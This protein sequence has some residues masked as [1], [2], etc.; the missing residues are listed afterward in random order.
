MTR[1]GPVGV[2][3]LRY[4]VFFVAVQY[5]LLLLASGHDAVK[6]PQWDRRFREAG[7]LEL[8]R[9]GV[10][11][12][13]NTLDELSA[14]QNMV[15]NDPP[16][17]YREDNGDTYEVIA[18]LRGSTDRARMAAELD[19]R[20]SWLLG[21]ALERQFRRVRNVHDI[22]WVHRLWFAQ[23]LLSS[24][25]VSVRGAIWMVPRSIEV[26]GNSFGT[27]G[28]HVS[29]SAVLAGAIWWGLS[30]GDSEMS[31][32]V[33]SL[34]GAGLIG[35]V[36]YAVG[37]VWWAVV[38]AR[39]GLPE[40]WERRGIVRGLCVLVALGAAF[41]L[42]VSGTFQRTNNALMGLVDHLEPVDGSRP[43]YWHGIILLGVVGWVVRNCVRSAANPLLVTKDRLGFVMTA[44]MLTGVGVACVG[45]VL[46]VDTSGFVIAAGC[47]V[48]GSFCG[49]GAMIAFLTVR[50]RL[51]RY[52]ALAAA[53]YTVPRK[54]FRCWALVTWI[55]V[56]GALLAWSELTTS[57]PGSATYVIEQ[58]AALVVMLTLMSSFVPGVIVTHLYIRR[59]DRHFSSLS[60]HGLA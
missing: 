11:A 25:E 19:R 56:F 43:A 13:K 1:F 41:A 36:L 49:I 48:G 31:G 34:A 9:R 51:R 4:L 40:T 55:V 30:A 14:R 57:R 23:R 18:I 2:D 53:G 12:R 59:I 6:S 20:R 42:A 16:G 32:V 27:F 5:V 37:R 17:G 7:A 21:V 29:V 60:I 28:K 10:F 58:W 8:Y 26:V 22:K 39:F 24:A 15:G 38:V 50:D 54:G 47:L 35:G 33:A 52:R 46:N 3:I 44:L 45:M